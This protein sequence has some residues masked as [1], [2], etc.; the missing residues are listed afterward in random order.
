[1][2]AFLLGRCS[3]TFAIWFVYPRRRK[4]IHLG[5]SRLKLL[6]RPGRRRIFLRLKPEARYRSITVVSNGHCPFLRGRAS[7]CDQAH[8]TRD[9]NPTQKDNT[10]GPFHDPIST[11][12]VRPSIYHMKYTLS[13]NI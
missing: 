1:M 2:G 13:N 4:A 6:A 9:S 7:L 8:Q 11:Y 3:L 10:K 12:K 5:T